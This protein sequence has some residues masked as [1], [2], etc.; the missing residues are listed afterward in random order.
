M[1]V[2]K[3]ESINDRL[4]AILKKSLYLVMFLHRPPSY[5]EGLSYTH[6]ISLYSIAIFFIFFFIFSL[7]ENKISD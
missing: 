6:Y 2:A 4:L 3:I 1:E 5:F 7:S